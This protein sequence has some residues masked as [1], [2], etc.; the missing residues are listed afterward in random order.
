MD[1]DAPVVPG[2]YRSDGTLVEF[3]DAK[4]EWARAGYAVLVEVAR[5]PEGHITYQ[6]IADAIQDSTGIQT[7]VPMHDWIGTPLALVA[8]M[9][10]RNGEPQLTALVVSSG[11]LDVGDGY[12][13]TFALAGQPLPKNIQRAAAETR[14]ECYDYFGRREPRGWDRTRLTGR[15]A[16]KRRAAPKP[17]P[18]AVA[19]PEPVAPKICPTCNLQLLPSGVCGNCD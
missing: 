14:I 17:R 9:C 3:A 5:R 1:A 11:T 19:R 7:R 2:S 8:E 12:G 16:T 4:Y 15:T 18:K 6:D 13:D 10:V